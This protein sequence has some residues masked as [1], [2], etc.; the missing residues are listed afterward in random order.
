VG[1]GQSV[2]CPAHGLNK[3]GV[4][5]R[6]L[7]GTRVFLSS[8]KCPDRYLGPS[9]LLFS[10]YRVF[11]QR[12]QSCQG[13]ELTTNHHLVPTPG[14]RGVI[15]L[16]PHV[17]SWRAQ[18]QLYRLLLLLLL[19]LLAIYVGYLQFTITYLKQNN[20]RCTVLLLFCGYDIR[21]LLH[22]AESFL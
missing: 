18:Q 4:L 19:Y 3:S 10:G 21:Y 1:T 12:G 17:A 9:S 22:G 6:L 8:P 14:M 20:V 13:V 16:L 7:T 11:V 15:S 2:Y 5:V